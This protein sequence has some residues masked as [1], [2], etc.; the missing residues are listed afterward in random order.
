MLKGFRRAAIIVVIASL[1]LSAILGITALFG[2]GFGEVQGKVLLT[3]V[4]IGVFGITILCHLA[5]VGRAARLVG[6]IGLVT[7]LAAIVPPLVLIWTPWSSFTS[8]GE[9][10]KAFGV[11]TVLAVSLAQANLLLLLVG[12][13]QPAIRIILWV[14]L[15]MMAILAIMI[16]LPI[17]TEGEIPGGA[18][19][20][21]WRWFG[22]VAILDVLGTVTLPVVGLV[23]KPRRQSGVAAEAAAETLAAPRIPIPADL[24]RRI[25]VSAAAVG[26]DPERHA[27]DAL[28]R[29]FPPTAG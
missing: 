4:T 8:S 28:D 26:V 7:S 9:W 1:V 2:A 5:I 25:A 29:A 21:Y 18:G 6:L 22:V 15:A 11:L 20:D 16:I 14:T 24:A 13:P 17:A 19:E 12:R 27:L 10:W 3:T 23:L